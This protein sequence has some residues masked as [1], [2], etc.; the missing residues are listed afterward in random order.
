MIIQHIFKQPSGGIRHCRGTLLNHKQRT[1][2]N[3]LNLRRIPLQIALIREQ[4]LQKRKRI[5]QYFC[6]RIPL[7][8]TRP[9]NPIRIIKRRR[10]VQLPTRNFRRVRVHKFI[11]FAIVEVV[12]LRF[13]IG[14]VVGYAVVGRGGVVYRGLGV[15]EVEQL[16]DVVTGTQG[17][18]GEC[19]PALGLCA[20]LAGGE[21]EEKGEEDGNSH[22]HYIK[23]S[24]LNKNQF[25]LNKNRA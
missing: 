19:A 1:H 15:E 9:R 22:Q 5:Q 4:L 18:E 14:Q 24:L 21:N 8:D 10:K 23:D 3:I 16:G 12:E 6:N 17:F 7:R 20:E 13:E 25:K 2:H 11:T